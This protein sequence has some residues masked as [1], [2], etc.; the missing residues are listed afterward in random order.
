MTAP[1]LLQLYPGAST[2]VPITSVY[3]PNGPL[4]PATRPYVTVN[5]VASVDGATA[6]DGVTEPLSSAGDK[7]IFFLLRALTDVVLVGAQTVRAEGYGSVSADEATRAARR[8]RGQRP[9]AAIAIVT[10]SLQLD[11]SAPL[12]TEATVE[13]FVITT[14]TA[15]PARVATAR[16]RANVI[17]AGHDS[18]DLAEAMRF[19]RA[20]HGVAA[21]LCEGGPT[22]N[23]QL[24]TR[25]LVDELCLTVAPTL[26]GGGSKP[27]FGD[28]ALP[29][30]A[31]LE[32]AS[33]LTDGSAL[34]LRYR[35]QREQPASSD[36]G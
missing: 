36:R 9:T 18:V 7:A 34:F 29:G 26:L 10:A 28:D 1:S 6:V 11:W 19:L 8:E 20:E 35:V 27:I 12:F 24:A 4:A 3:R 31:P 14:R 21:V 15:D 17:L 22:L 25:G 16:S 32:L 5:M 33:A 23:H 13:P 2:H 30:G